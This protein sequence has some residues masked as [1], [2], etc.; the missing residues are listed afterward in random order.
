MRL[1]Y[2]SGNQMRFLSYNLADGSGAAYE[3]GSYLSMWVRANTERDNVIKFKAF[4]INKVEPST[5][6][7]CDEVEVTVPHDANKGW[8]EVKVPLKATRTYYGFAILPM[9]NSGAASGDG[10]Y[11]YV[12]NIAIYSSIS[13]IANA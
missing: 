13:P 10:Q 4:Y 1:K 3:K 11:F 12:D 7:S 5:Q 8:V 9:K 2:N 6:S